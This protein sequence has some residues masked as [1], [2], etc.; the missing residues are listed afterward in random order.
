[1]IT[2]LLNQPISS[3]SSIFFRDEQRVISPFKTT[4]LYLL[5][6]LLL[7]KNLEGFIIG[8]E[9]NPGLPLLKLGAHLGH[10]LDQL[11]LP[12]PV[13]SPIPGNK[14][15]FSFGWS[16]PLCQDSCRVY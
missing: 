11:G 4:Y 10:F 2:G 9:E 12:L 1:M 5:R 15:F 8:I 7:R 13:V 3:I 6:K 14:L 16:Y